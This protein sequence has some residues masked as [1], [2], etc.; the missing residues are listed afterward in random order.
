MMQIRH[1]K[2]YEIKLLDNAS[3]AINVV[4]FSDLFK[5]APDDIAKRD[6]LFYAAVGCCKVKVH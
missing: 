6:Y 5:I 3:I 1:C 2:S 4:F